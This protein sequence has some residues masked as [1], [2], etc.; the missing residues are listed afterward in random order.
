MASV[1]KI[2]NGWQVR[3]RKQGY[4]Q[5]SKNFK[6]HAQAKVY[7]N[8]VETEMD[9]GVFVDTKAKDFT[10]L[11]VI[12]NN[13]IEHDKKFG[14]EIGKPKL[15]AIN[16][17]S[18]YFNDVDIHDL[19]IDMLFDFAAYRRKS[20]CAS[21]LQQQLY[22]LRQAIRH[23]RIKTEVD[24]V[25]IVIEELARKKIITASKKRERRLENGEYDLLISHCVGRLSYMS[26]VIDL[27]IATCM[28]QAELHRL[29]LSDIDFEKQIITLY[30]KDKRAEGGRSLH[31]IPL[32]HDIRSLI[33][34]NKNYIRNRDRLIHVTKSSSIGDAFA[35]VR[36]NAG[37]N[38]LRFHDLRHEG[39]SRLFEIQKM[40]V[41]QVRLMSGHSSLDQLSIYTNI[42]PE[43]LLH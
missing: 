36:K 42:K 39:L 37:I 9:A 8:R 19:T 28:R 2:K 26:F 14:I 7:A 20:V 30:R 31:K 12:L 10:K 35:K 25:E 1:I 38:D 13:L 24:V 43:S 17:L 21:T 18:T 27:A 16:N 41:E 33:T 29:K 4:P 11:N 5:I 22:F 40:S 23:S 3:I 34:S 6:S 32:L 15:S